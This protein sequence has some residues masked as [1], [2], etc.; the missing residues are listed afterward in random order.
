MRKILFDFFG[1]GQREALAR[2]ECDVRYRYSN[3]KKTP[4]EPGQYR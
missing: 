3:G 4:G 2:R 1:F